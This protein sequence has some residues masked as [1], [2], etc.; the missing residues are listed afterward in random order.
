MQGRIFKMIAVGEK[1]WLQYRKDLQ[2]IS[3]LTKATKIF[4]DFGELM[5]KNWLSLIGISLNSSHLESKGCKICSRAATE[6]D[7][8]F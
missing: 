4:K 7:I 6:P 8:F 5:G 1:R 3:T 2:L